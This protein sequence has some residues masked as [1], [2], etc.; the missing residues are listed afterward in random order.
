VRSVHPNGNLGQAFANVRI[1]GDELELVRDNVVELFLAGVGDVPLVAEFF[2]TGAEAK[3]QV[4]TELVVFVGGHLIRQ[5]LVELEDAFGIFVDLRDRFAVLLINVS[6]HLK[7]LTIAL[8]ED[9]AFLY[10]RVWDGICHDRVELEVSGDRMKVGGGC[11]EFG[12]DCFDVLGAE[13]RR[14][15][16]EE[17]AGEGEQQCLGFRVI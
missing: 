14:W 16:S 7:V 12:E 4:A 8:V 2:A 13:A 11:V 9:T 10:G 3:E 17:Q 1:F 5:L 15:Q 6:A